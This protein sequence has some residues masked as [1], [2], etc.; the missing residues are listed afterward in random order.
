MLN[1]ID[2]VHYNFQTTK[3][4][5]VPK[6]EPIHL[7]E[8]DWDI[9][10]YYASIAYQLL[11]LRFG[12]WR[13]DFNPSKRS[14]TDTR[15]VAWARYQET[16]ASTGI[17]VED[18]GGFEPPGNP[19]SKMRGKMLSEIYN[20]IFSPHLQGEE[21]VAAC[22][23]TSSIM[24]RRT[25][26]ERKRKAAEQEKTELLRAGG[27]L[28]PKV[29]KPQETK[30]ERRERLLSIAEGGI[31]RQNDLELSGTKI[32]VTETPITTLPPQTTILERHPNSTE[33]TLLMMEIDTDASFEQRRVTIGG[34]TPPMRHFKKLRK[35]SRK[36]RAYR[37]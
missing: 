35:R 36:Y 33:V 1:H 20:E 30:N 31:G 2:T 3:E 28:H 32:A 14:L 29:I 26:V 21:Y 15:T 37:P 11:S 12:K 18:L 34:Y 27:I 22:Q 6:K 23:K 7:T 8:E 10:G 13:L 17:P 24:A 25:W 9:F 16:M 19:A 4:A 5:T